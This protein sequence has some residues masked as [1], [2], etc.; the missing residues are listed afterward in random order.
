MYPVICEIQS[1]IINEELVDNVF[2]C[3]CCVVIIFRI[4]LIMAVTHVL[5]NRVSDLK[6]M[7]EKPGLAE[8][9]HEDVL[10]PCL[11]AYLSHRDW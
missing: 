4:C 8:L 6:R 7:R 5:K 2:V 3:C 11:F 10:F 1:M 9:S